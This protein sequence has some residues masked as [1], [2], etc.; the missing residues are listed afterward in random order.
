MDVGEVAAAAAGD[1]DFAPGLGV[2]LQKR[3]ATAA[4]AGCGGTHEA[5]CTGTD[6]DYIELPIGLAGR[7]HAVSSG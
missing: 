4:L 2:V 6:N 3:D 7:G 1:E 5:G